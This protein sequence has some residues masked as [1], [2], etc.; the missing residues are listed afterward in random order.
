MEDLIYKH[1]TSYFNNKPCVDVESLMEDLNSKTE[2][3][4]DELFT[5]SYE[6][7]VKLRIKKEY[8]NN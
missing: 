1:I 7:L 5:E 6:G 8:E 2:K 3:E 4:L